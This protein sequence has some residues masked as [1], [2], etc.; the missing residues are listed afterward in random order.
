MLPTGQS[1]PCILHCLD[2]NLTTGDDY[3]LTLVVLELGSHHPNAVEHVKIHYES[4]QS[5]QLSSQKTLLLGAAAEAPT[6]ELVLKTT[7]V[8]KE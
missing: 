4:V 6:G 3:L 8:G 5:S 1:W 2:S 7:A